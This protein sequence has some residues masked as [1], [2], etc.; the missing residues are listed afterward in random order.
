MVN[1]DLM[2]VRIGFTEYRLQLLRQEL[3]RLI[4]ELPGL[5]ALK[6]ILV[7]DLLTEKI[8]PSSIIELVI[9][10]ETTEL[11]LDRI[12]FFVSHLRPTVGVDLCV[13]T[14]AE[15]AGLESTNLAMYN[16]IKPEGILYEI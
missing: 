4:S 7:G 13:Y 9:V 2:P 5:G 12:D 6:V 10:Q 16:R 8:G 3:E 11:Y 1:E 15:F 14:P